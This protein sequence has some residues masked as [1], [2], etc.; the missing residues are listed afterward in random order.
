LF[1]ANDTPPPKGQ[2]EGI[3]SPPYK[4]LFINTPW[5]QITPP[6]VPTRKNTFENYL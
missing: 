4:T 5:I 1:L 6:L 3:S 2:E